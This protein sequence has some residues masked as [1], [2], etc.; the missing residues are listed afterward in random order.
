MKRFRKSKS[1]SVG[2]D[3]AER[4]DADM[5]VASKVSPAGIVTFGAV[6][7]VRCTGSKLHALN[8]DGSAV[9]ALR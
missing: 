8:V 3:E 4:A 7:A 6:R 1:L 2:N 9:P 5:V